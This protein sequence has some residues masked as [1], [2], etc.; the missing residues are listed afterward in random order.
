MPLLQQPEL[1]H[2]LGKCVKAHSKLRFQAACANVF[3]DVAPPTASFAKDNRPCWCS[4]QQ[5]AEGTSSQPRLTE[6]QLPDFSLTLNCIFTD[7]VVKPAGIHHDRSCIAAA[8]TISTRGHSVLGAQGYTGGVHSLL[9]I[10]SQIGSL[11]LPLASVCP[12]HVNPCD[13]SSFMVSGGSQ[14]IRQLVHLETLSRTMMMLAVSS[15]GPRTQSQRHSGPSPLVRCIAVQAI[16]IPSQ[17]QLP[18]TRPFSRTG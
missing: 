2:G 13:E 4:W 18:L 14:V 8:P 1:D 3:P 5:N 7:V 15:A 11:R 9:F 6:H 12:G 17:C 10:C 16:L